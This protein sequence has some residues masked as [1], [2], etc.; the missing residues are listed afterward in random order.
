MFGRK[1]QTTPTASEA[2]VNVPT[3]EIEQIHV[4]PQRFY[5][6]PRH[7]ANRTFVIM[8][9]LVIVVG[10][11]VAV[12]LAMWK[13]GP[14]PG[15][16]PTGTP[17]PTGVPA[18]VQSPTPTETPVSPTPVPTPEPT[19]TPAP[20]PTPTVSGASDEDSDG[21]TLNEE[22]LYGTSPSNPD[23]D[24]DG[25][26]DGAEVQSGYSP[27]TAGKTLVDDGAFK[28][29]STSMGFQLTIPDSWLGQ[30][31]TEAAITTFQIDSRFG[32]YVRATRLINND[33]LDL[34]A[35]VSRQGNLTTEPVT[36]NGV[37]GM[38]TSETPPRYYFLTPV[39]TGVVELRYDVSGGNPSLLSTYQ[40]IVKS[41]RWEV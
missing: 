23:T 15:N 37:S 30:E 35:W 39:E 3:Q 10:L 31:N 40:A 16:V 36:I 13:F 11:L 29:I 17:T 26:K 5:L 34:A 12:V 14:L 41:F 19:A 7:K 33:R 1:K 38:K 25:Y 4:M 32:E 2:G 6:T 21:L 9:I 22:R 27:V 20:E 8:G 18:A 24:S 28:K